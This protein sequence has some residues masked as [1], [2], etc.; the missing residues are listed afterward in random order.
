[1]L[2]RLSLILALTLV[3]F[4]AAAQNTDISTKSVTVCATPTIDTN[5]YAAGDA[6]GGLLTFSNA[7]RPNAFSGVITGA[8]ILDKDAE[9]ANLDLIIFNANPSAS[10]VTNNAAL[11]LADADLSKAIEPISISSH[12]AF[13]SNDNGISGS[14]SLTRTVQTSSSVT[15]YGALR[16][17]ATPTYTSASDLTV[18]IGVLQD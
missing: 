1:M 7:L 5:I 4:I 15:L 12:T 10:T 2:K 3:P 8:Y 17:V 18:C 13:N 14:G 11:D 16:A 9:G 6:V